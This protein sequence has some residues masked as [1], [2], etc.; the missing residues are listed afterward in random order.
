MS[1]L[2][3]IGNM[4]TDCLARQGTCYSWGVG[5]VG[6]MLQETA[7]I[8]SPHEICGKGLAAFEWDSLPYVSKMELFLGV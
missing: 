1:Q 2:R 4:G 7:Q 6:M 8:H 5:K 3:Y